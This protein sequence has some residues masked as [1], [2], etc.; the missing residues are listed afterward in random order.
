MTACPSFSTKKGSAGIAV[1]HRTLKIEEGIFHQKM[2]HEQGYKTAISDFG[3]DPQHLI[4]H[5]CNIIHLKSKLR[6]KNVI[7][8]I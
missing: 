7:Y 5:F 8:V 2:H 1:T 6:N 3:F 4:V